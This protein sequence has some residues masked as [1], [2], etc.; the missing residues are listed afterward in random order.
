M[1]YGLSELSSI[2]SRILAKVINEIELANRNSEMDEI[3]EKYGVIIEEEERFPINTRTYR[4]L[5]IGEL[6]GSIKD[7]QMT[8]KKIGIDPDNIEFMDYEQSKRI[9]ARRLEYSNEYS[10]IIY[11][12]TPHKIEGMGDTNSLLALIEANPM[13]YPRLI[14]SK[15]NTTSGA[16]KIS[17]SGFKD[18][19]RRTYYYET[20]L[21]E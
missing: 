17:I 8:A 7:Y 4:I 15:A 14:R 9:D 19:L 2:K 18:Y 6:A 3:L 12:P 11:G 13:K 5:V 16:L 21:A 10:D 1:Q 20:L